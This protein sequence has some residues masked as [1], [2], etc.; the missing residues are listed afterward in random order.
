M[1]AARELELF[2]TQTDDDLL[3]LLALR[4][5]QYAKAAASA[6]IYLD[7]YSGERD[8]LV[9]SDYLVQ[10]NAEDATDYAKRLEVTEAVPITTKIV[11]RTAGAVFEPDPEHDVPDQIKDY[12]TNADKNGL[13]HT[14]IML[15]TFCKAL[16]AGYMLVYVDSTATSDEPVSKAQA[17]LEGRRTILNTYDPR[18]ILNWNYDETGLAWVHVLDSENTQAS[19]FDE[20]LASELH[21]IMTRNW[22]FRLRVR[23]TN[24]GQ[25]V[26]R[27]DPVEHKMGQCPC[28]LLI[29]VH[30][31]EKGP[32]IGKSYIRTSVR[33]DLAAMRAESMRAMVLHIHGTPQL[34]RRFSDDEWK[35]INNAFA[36]EA[37]AKGFSAVDIDYAAVGR[38]IK[39]GY[40]AYHIL[41]GSDSDMFYATLDV[42]PLEKLKEAVDDYRAKA[43]QQAGF[44]GAEVWGE[45]QKV[46][47]ESGISKAFDYAMEQGPQL[48]LL[49]MVMG[50]FDT[51]ILK[52]VCIKAGITP[53]DDTKATYPQPR[54]VAPFSQLMAEYEHLVDNDYPVEVI[55]EAKVTIFSRLVMFDG[56]D[57]GAKKAL[58]EKIKAIDE[59]AL[60]NKKMLQ[61]ESLQNITESDNGGN[62]APEQSNTE[63][64][65]KE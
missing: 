5:P 23:E 4:H 60:L 63:A 3:E 7:V 52:L 64:M 57:A 27:L 17:K 9:N 44:D 8:R 36:Q 11:N 35:D 47:A 2:T 54:M 43:E 19:F 49:S 31:R 25:T 45:N 56:M 6:Q 37:A 46:S 16:V 59:Q 18:S 14:Q 13:T 65:S 58:I 61:D 48:E 38:K 42:A 24:K 51:K 30:D 28:E 55:T 50:M 53:T 21:M 32:G 34:C 41:K 10:G 1:D 29:F 15:D 40:T 62:V 26:E 12:L 33:S 39:L 22:V 20:Q